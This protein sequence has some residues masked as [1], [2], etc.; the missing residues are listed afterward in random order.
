MREK[1]GP[2]RVAAVGLGAG[3]LAYY[4]RPSEEWVF[5]EI[6]PAVWR[7]AEEHFDFLRESRA[8]ALEVLTGDARLRMKEA[9]DG[10]FD[11]IVLDA[12][13]ADSIPTHLLTAEAVELY[14]TKLAPGG[15]IVFHVSNRSLDLEPLLGKVA[16]RA[17]LIAVGCDDML[18]DV[19]VG[20]LRSHWVMLVAREEDRGPLGA[21]KSARWLTVVPL[22]GAPLWTDDFSNVLRALKW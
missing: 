21:K 13:S 8:G 3:S 1:Q 22:P 12:F 6:D 5:Y 4:A 17:G 7:V 14:K 2:R 19:E 20:K 9:A 18:D 11:L 16:Q 15:M 10:S